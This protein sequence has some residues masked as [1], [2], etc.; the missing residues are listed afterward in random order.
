M[1]V[2]RNVRQLIAAHPNIQFILTTDTK[3]PNRFTPLTAYVIGVTTPLSRTVLA[4]LQLAGLTPAPPWDDPELKWNN[5]E[6]KVYRL[7]TESTYTVAVTTAITRLWYFKNVALPEPLIDQKCDNDVVATLLVPQITAMA[8]LVDEFQTMLHGAD[9][10]AI[11]KY[12]KSV[13]FQRQREEK[14]KR[15]AEH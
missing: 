12:L 14:L 1:S 10:F 6:L 5:P 7:I 13:N 8:K 11:S 3:I 2:G 15:C 9:Y 4:T